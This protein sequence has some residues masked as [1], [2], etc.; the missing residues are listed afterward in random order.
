LYELHQE[1][2][3]L[4]DATD[5]AVILPHGSCEHKFISAATFGFGCDELGSGGGHRVA[6]NATFELL[7]QV[8][9]TTVHL[10]QDTGGATTVIHTFMTPRV[11]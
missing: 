2:I 8:A 9:K 6:A 11:R 1:T 3:A 4:A 5:V 10:R 7:N